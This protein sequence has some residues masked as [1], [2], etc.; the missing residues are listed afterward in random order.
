MKT[1]VCHIS[2]V[3]SLKDDRIFFKECQSL[4]RNNY[5]VYL[6]IPALENHSLNGVNIR[7][8]PEPKGRLS[9]LFVAQ[10]K[11]LSTALKTKAN[12]YHFHDPELM[13]LGII[14]RLMGKKVVYDVH[15][16]LPKQILYKPWIKPAVLR[17][18]LSGLI[19]LFEQFSCL[20]F[21]GIVAVTDD[22]ARK[23]KPEKTI[24]LRNLPI[25]SITEKP[26]VEQESKT[27]KT[28]FVYAGGLTRIRGVKEICRAVAQ[29]HSKA[30]LWL[31][32]AWESDEYREECLLAGSESY[33]KYLGFMPMPEVYRH[34]GQADV[35]IA[36]L[37]P[38]KNY[39]T[40]LPVKAFEYMAQ[41]KPI[42]MSDFDYWKEIFAGTALF[43]DAYQINEIVE[44]MQIL[45]DDVHVRAQLGR[46]GRQ[47]VEEE[48]NWEKEVEKLFSL[49]DRILKNGDKED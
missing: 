30:E 4:M 6:V 11:A 40:S 43:A 19:Y 32:G 8:I 34:I 21:Q 1:K 44:K 49:Y 27:T 9:R 42:L 35:G 29:V 24:I 39:L 5:D 36:M 12:L 31:I 48:L 20:F 45:I 3:H 37:Y 15:E 17:K 23:Y 46:Y 13:F 41:G 26:S 7:A 2:T 25:L 28:I 22:I 18:L 10:W 14:L 38:I 47:R 16:D 33:I